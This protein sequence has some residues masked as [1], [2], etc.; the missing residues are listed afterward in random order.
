[1][2]VA[3]SRLPS[4]IRGYGYRSMKKA[5]SIAAIATGIS[6]LSADLPM[7]AVKKI[8]YALQRTSFGRLREGQTA[9]N[10]ERHRPNVKQRRRTEHCAERHG[11][12][13]ASIQQFG[14]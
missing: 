8:R 5:M 6:S 13:F 3:I 9:L 2:V 1:M 11:C 7:Q 14:S 12:Y 10:S 4:A